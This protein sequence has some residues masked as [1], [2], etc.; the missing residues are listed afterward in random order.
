MCGV[1]DKGRKNKHLST[2][3]RGQI[4]ALHK[5]GYTPYRIGKILGRSDDT[6]RN[7]LKR[8]TITVIKGAFE[9]TQYEPEAGQNIYERNRKRCKGTRKIKESRRFLEYIEYEVKKKKRSFD[10]ARGYALKNGLFTKE[11]V[12]C[13]TTLYHYADKGIIG[14]KNIDLPEK[15]SRKAKGERRERIHKRLKGRSIEERPETVNEK[16]EFGHWEIDLIIGKKSNDD[17][18]LTLTERKTKR[19][20]LRRLKGKTIEEVEKALRGIEKITPCFDKIFK[21]ITSD[22]GTE[23]SRL[24]QLEEGRGTR[25]YYAHPYSSWERGLNENTNRIVRRFIRKG[26]EIKKY[27][28]GKIR[29]IEDWIN[30]LPRRILGYATAEECFQEEIEKILGSGRKIWT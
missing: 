3:E 20:I 5:E 4:A 11:E 28:R 27:S 26:M 23:F 9:R 10:A 15:T 24:Y 14:V 17:V 16:Q 8:G 13:V 25:V 22:N 30:T 6:I 2:Y 18:L 21:S 19:E 12:V 7:E 1:I 29:K